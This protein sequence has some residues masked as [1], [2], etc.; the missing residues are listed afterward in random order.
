MVR[1]CGAR[2]NGQK[3]PR[4]SGL[5]FSAPTVKIPLREMLSILTIR[6]S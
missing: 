4:K 6:A 1:S 5:E 3:R 2:P